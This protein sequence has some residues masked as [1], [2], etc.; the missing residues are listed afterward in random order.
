MFIA[1]FICSIIII[2]QKPDDGISLYES[3]GWWIGDPEDFG[4]DEARLQ[5]AYN[6]ASYQPYMRSV[7]IVRHG[8]LVAEWYYNDGGR[9]TA[10][11]IHS[12]SKSFMSAIFGIAHEMGYIPDLDKKMMDYFP[13]YAYLNLPAWKYNITLR[14]LLQMKAGL[15]FDDSADAWRAYAGSSDWVKYA[16]E[17]PK[18]HDPGEDWDYATPQTNILSV[19]LTKA[20]G[21]STK[22]FADLYLFEPLGIT[23][24][25]WSQD[26]QGYYCGGHEMYFT[27]R[28]MARFGLLY[29][30]NGTL[31]D[32]EIVSKDWV[33]ESIE[34]YE[35]GNIIE[36][37]FS[38]IPKDTA[39]YG[40]QWWT[41]TFSGHFCYMTRGC[42][43]QVIYCV[44]SL[45]LIVVTTATGTV[46]DDPIV[47][48]Q[49]PNIDT[50]VVYNIFTS[51]VSD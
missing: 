1:G 32:V 2:D 11:H 15:E 23:I 18:S 34:N 40:Y 5:L 30:N 37:I 45:D 20:T 39:G 46:M 8:V 33:L 17:L 7:L 50:F 42:C 27:P 12:S 25:H 6:W 26:P 10:H 49:I 3:E 9:Y 13:E 35:Y 38:Y 29:L 47:F 28:D 41:A 14:H 48:H 16:L 44:P 51:I 43:G 36:E 31:D 4:F 21:M 19:I 22:E 24:D